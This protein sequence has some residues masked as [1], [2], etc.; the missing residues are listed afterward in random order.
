MDASRIILN[1]VRE[2]FCAKTASDVTSTKEWRI[3]HDRIESAVFSREN[4]W[5]FDLPV[6]W[7]DAVLTQ[8]QLSRR[9]FEQV[10]TRGHAGDMALDV[11]ARL[12]TRLSF[13]SGEEG[14]D[15]RIAD[16]ANG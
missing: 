16:H 7:R 4:L 6:E 3:P 11:G 12:L 5:I 1:Q 9:C 15:H 2:I 10:P 8:A 13:V 14:G